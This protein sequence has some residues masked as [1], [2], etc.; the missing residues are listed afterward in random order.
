MSAT[1]KDKTMK[2]DY[3]I[4]DYGK[5]VLCSENYLA[6]FRRLARL[7]LDALLAENK[8][9][10]SAKE[11]ANVAIAKL[12]ISAQLEIENAL[13]HKQNSQLTD[14]LYKEALRSVDAF[15][16]IIKV[17]SADESDRWD[18]LD[19]EPFVKWIE[20]FPKAPPCR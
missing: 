9:L 2:L 16:L 14:A 17:L 3:V 5:E 18:A 15:A 11:D 8:T 10:R 6:E 4:Q 7:E 12:E 13:L 20:S 19:M 1:R